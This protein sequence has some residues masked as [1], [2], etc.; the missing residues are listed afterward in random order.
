MVY[1]RPVLKPSCE[2]ASTDAVALHAL[3]LQLAGA[4]DGGGALAG[5]L[6]GRLLVMAAQ[7][8]LAVDAFALELLLERAQ[9][10]VDIVVANEDLHKVPSLSG[11]EWP[12]DAGPPDTNAIS[13]R[14]GSSRDGSRAVAGA[15]TSAG[16][17]FQAERANSRA[18]CGPGKGLFSFARPFVPCR[19][20]HFWPLAR[21][22]RIHIV[23]SRHP[24]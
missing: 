9:R 15:V 16:S 5:A 22:S 7:L 21:P 13:I 23:R 18:P 3:A 20:I 2:A 4:A 12:D 11:F 1:R 17:V 6:L 14:A 8:H 19:D 24:S 10:L